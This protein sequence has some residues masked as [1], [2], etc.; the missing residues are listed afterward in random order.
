ML[1]PMVFV[2]I[3]LGQEMRAHTW[4][5]PDIH[6]IEMLNLAKQEDWLKE[7]QK[8]CPIKVIQATARM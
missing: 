4:E 6:Q 1:I 7:T 8:N 3:H 2:R 5:N